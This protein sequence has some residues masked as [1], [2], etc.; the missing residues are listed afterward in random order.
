MLWPT[1]PLGAD[2]GGGDG[3][4]GGSGDS[5]VSELRNDLNNC[6]SSSQLYCENKDRTDQLGSVVPLSRYQ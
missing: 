1:G 6:Q 3:G 5:W 4:G 2:C